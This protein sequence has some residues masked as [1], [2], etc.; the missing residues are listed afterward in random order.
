MQPE[1]SEPLEA[2]VGVL[3]KLNRAPEALKRLDAVAAQFP[4]VPVALNAKG[5]VL[6]AT[7][8]PADAELAFKAAIERQP[9]WWVPY[10]GLAVAQA[11]NHDNDAAVATLRGAIAKVQQPQPLQTELAGLFERLGKTEDAIQVY[12]DELRKNPEADV[13]ANNLAML[14][15]TYKK[16]SQSLDRA[17]T[18]SAR[19]AGSTNAA[20]LDTYGWVLYKRGESA[21]AV[22]ALQT[23]LSKTPDSPISLYHLGMAQASAGQDDAARESLM[24]S[25]KSGKSF[26]G[27]DEAKATLDKIATVGASSS[28][29]PKT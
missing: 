22:T 12:E 2:L 23:A 20:F 19:F 26:F 5:K 27:M 4:T 14:L 8:H 6:L 10:S 7:Q 15:I 25:L 29:P 1:S 17:K 28:A 16:D 13:A 21:A 24:R 11:A 18:L 3:V 9:K